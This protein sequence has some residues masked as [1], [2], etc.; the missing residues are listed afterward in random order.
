MPTYKRAKMC[1]ECP[2]RAKS[3]RGWLGPL[4]IDDLEMSVH[5]PIKTAGGYLGDIGDLI[6]HK[7][8][9]KL[10][11]VDSPANIHEQGQQCVGMIRYANAVGKLS[12][13]PVICEFQKR[14]DGVKD[15]AVIPRGGLR[16]HHDISKAFKQ[17]KKD[18]P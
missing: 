7:D 4:T 17:Y 14:L 10:A 15:V 5:G 6:C 1:N 12:C 11:N 13:D 8:I 2:F 18:R 16:D 9:A 3:A